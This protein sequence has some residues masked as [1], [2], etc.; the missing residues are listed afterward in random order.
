[1]TGDPADRNAVERD[2][3]T[4]RASPQPPG[5]TCSTGPA[6]LL[7]PC[8]SRVTL[9]SARSWSVDWADRMRVHHFTATLSPRDAVGHHTLAVDDL[10]REMGH[11]TTLCPE[12]PSRSRRPG[13]DFRDHLVEEPADVVLYQASTGSPVADHLLGGPNPLCSTTTTSRRLGRS[14]CGNH[15]SVPSSM[16]AVVS[17]LAS[18]GE[19]SPR[20]PTVTSTPTNSSSSASKMFASRR[21]CSSL[22]R[23]LIAARRPEVRR[24]CCSSAVSRRTS[25]SRTS[26]P[27]W[28]NCVALV[29]TPDCGSSVPH[30]RPATR[31]H[32]APLPTGSPPVPSSSPVRCR[33]RISSRPT[34]RLTSSSVSASTRAFACR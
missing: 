17:W 24:P 15:I 21:S 9:V 33:M 32:C 12:H 22:P 4:G 5:P 18:P 28:P 3:R 10:L 26:S 6:S 34:V 14:I 30:H 29:P 31:T 11:D 20:L 25:D 2:L 8:P 16:P 23:L 27:L 19:R 7:R 1:M 13:C